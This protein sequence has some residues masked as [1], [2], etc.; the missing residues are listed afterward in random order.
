M[1]YAMMSIGVLGFVVWSWFLASPHS[2]MSA[3]INFAICW[4]GLVLIGTLNGKNSVS[5]TQSAGNLSL[6][7]SISKTQSASETT[8]E[9]SFNFLAFRLYY[10]TLFGNRAEFL[11]DNWLTWFIG[12]VEGDGAIQTYG[13]GTK[14]RFVLTQKE[15]AIL[16]YIQKKLGVGIVK[17]FPQGT[18]GNKNDFCRLIV[19]NPSHI[20]L[21]AFLFNGNLAMDHRIQQLSL[22]V[23][24]L[25]N[26]FGDNTVIFINTAPVITLQDSWLSG[27]TD[28]EGCF[29][30]S[31]TANGR[32]SLGHVIRMRYLLDQKDSS[33]LTIINN[34]F[35]VGK[36]TLRSQTD[37]IYRYTVTGFKPTNHIVSYFKV[38]PLFT[39]KAQSFQKWLEIH[40]IV[41]KK[42]HLCE[43]GLDRVRILQKEINVNNSMTNKTGSA[44]P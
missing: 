8:R 25:N 5:Y 21:L 12:F 22:W 37:D 3:Y 44:H 34:I 20:L 10:D 17:H 39:K 36:V 32:H 13:N 4:N 23:K 30:V 6:Y 38:F 35:G 14:V 7:S 43:Q 15:S 24:S 29:N 42:Q 11:S 2:D 26:R 9:T 27:F 28:A 16:Y 1:V 18:S 33:I 40:D 41:S 31:I 19:D